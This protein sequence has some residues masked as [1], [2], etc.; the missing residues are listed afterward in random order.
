MDKKLFGLL[1]AL[2]TLALL[3]IIF[4]QW[5]WISNSYQSKE[6]Q[7]VTTVRQVLLDTADEIELREAEKYFEMYNDLLREAE[8]PE[9][10]T[11]SELI[12]R[13]GNGKS[14]DAHIFS[15]GILEE[16]FKLSSSFLDT[17]VDS[18]LFKRITNKKVKTKILKDIDAGSNRVE[19]TESFSRLK[20]YERAQFED[21]F[22]NIS[23]KIPIHRRVTANDIST[24]INDELTLRG[25]ESKFQFA[26]YSNDLGTK[27]RTQRFDLDPETTFRVSLFDNK[28][29]N[30]GYQ[31]Y[32]NFYEQEREVF[33]SLIGMTILSLLFTTVIF[34][35]FYSA[36]SQLFKQRQISQIKN[37]FINNMTHEFKTPIATINLA[38]DA[39][40]NPKVKASDEFTGKYLKM[41]RDEN[42]RM[43][44]QV[45]NVLRISKL[46][47]N[48]LDLPKERYD[49][50]DIIEDSIS[51]IELIVDDRGGYINSHLGALK[52]NV[53]VNESHI[54]NVIVNI[55]DNAVKYSEDE[56]KIDI[57]TENI[58][59][60]V[61]LKIRDQGMGMSK[62]ALKK[63]F[64]K[65]YRVPT[66]DIHNVK[67]HGLGLSYVKRI[68]D[69]HDAQVS[70]ESDQG[71][72]STF[73]IKLHL[74]S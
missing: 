36:L 22:S 74:I 4:V 50:H 11:F 42:H 63:I 12:Y 41:I 13:I 56:P 52:T 43:H 61:V 68:L 66:G 24:I 19:K 53:L 21:A 48:E 35:A 71:K 37:D 38:L 70:V 10:V 64:E 60:Y 17:D 69:D 26:I 6:S 29:L 57:Y 23:A 67:G 39:L 7:F 25:I 62:A 58:K 3:G 18:I 33:G 44:E 9:N 47:K 73:I 32:V 16:D 2:M 59:N 15:D 49:L 30:I 1:I 20:P 55:L 34:V 54:T 46:D 65:F 31:L 14:N 28:D 45:E 72:G 40:K 8:N 5:Y 27:V 51:H